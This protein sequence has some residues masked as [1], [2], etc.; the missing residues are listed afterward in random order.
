LDI[1]IGGNI[2]I[3]SKYGN[4][5]TKTDII[6]RINEY[7]NKY[8]YVPTLKEFTSENNTPSLGTVLNKFG[9]WKNALYE[10]NLKRDKFKYNSFSDKEILDKLYQ[11]Y[12]E[13]GVPTFRDLDENKDYPNST[14]IVGRFGTFR[15]A[16][17]CAHIPFD[18]KQKTFKTYSKEDVLNLL[19]VHTQEK[20]KSNF[21][22]LTYKEI[23][24]I[25]EMP[26]P[27]TIKKYFGSLSNAYK[28]IGYNLEEY[29]KNAIKN[30][31]LDKYKLACDKYGVILGKEDIDKLSRSELCSTNTIQRYFGTL[32][33]LQKLCGLTPNSIGSG[34]TKEEMI[35]DLKL[36]AKKLGRVPRRDDL[37]YFKD[38]SSN[39]TYANKF[40]SFINALHLAGLESLKNKYL[41]LN[42]TPCYSSFE[43]DFASMLENKSIL[44]KKDELYKKYIIGY[45]KR[46]T[47]DFV[48][49]LNSHRYFV[50]IFGMNMTEYKKKTVKKIE[51]CRENNINLISFYPKDFEKRNKEKLYQLLLTKI[52]E[53]DIDDKKVI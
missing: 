20:L 52:D 13:Y 31:I 5:Y 22:L 42:G 45:N 53:L 29:N 21:C 18:K 36:L 26:H 34:K 38:I 6:N 49:N 44:Y 46:S 43:F 30:N 4:R 32:Y 1:T 33:N 27:N 47:F 10:C 39:S 19:K 24:H 40:G 28:L 12:I 9:S 51:V 50:E 17:E 7:Y 16:L 2:K 48:F 3:M 11:Y 8:N 15:N 25:P 35:D 14:T 37:L 41:T 23:K